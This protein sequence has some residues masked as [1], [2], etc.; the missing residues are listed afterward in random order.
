MIKIGDIFSSNT[1]GKC[2][3]LHRDGVSKRRYFVK[4]LD[5]GNVASFEASHIMSGSI[6]DT[7]ARSVCGIGRIGQSVPTTGEYRR[8]YSIWRSMIRR[9]FDPNHKSYNA[10]KDVRICERWLTFSNFVTDCT[11]LPGYDRDKVAIGE[12]VLDKD[13]KQRFC[14]NKIYSPDTCMWVSVSANSR[15]QDG[16][17]KRFVAVSPQGKTFHDYNITDF[18]RKHN[19]SRTGISAVLRNRNKTSF[20]WRFYYDTSVDGEIS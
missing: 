6:R 19:L 1:C 16:Q 12:L 4:F 18:A 14:S 10:Y 7:L 3:V 15:I 8:Y 13:N 5:T 2:I 11:K 17:Q 20:G 9:C